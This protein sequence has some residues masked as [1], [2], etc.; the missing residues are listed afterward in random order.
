MIRA[1]LVSLALMAPLPALAVD[2]AHLDQL[3]AA[4][5]RADD[6]NWEAIEND[7][8]TEWA[9]SGSPAMDLL[10]RRGQ[11][12]LEHDD[13]AAALDHLTAL[14]DHAP[15]FAEGWNLRATALFA[16]GMYGP[17]LADLQK[18]LALEPRHF[19]ALSG[20][21]ILLE[22]LDQPEKALAAYGQALAIHPHMPHVKEAFTRLNTQLGKDI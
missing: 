17:A 9:R 6:T 2:Q 15:E 12:A 18:V 22:D 5:T 19:V 10:L 11:A 7:I 16:A 4:L 14:T 20:V 3:F 21:A 1:A 13:L 8:R